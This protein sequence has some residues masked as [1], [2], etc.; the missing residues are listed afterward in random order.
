[1]PFD[2]AWQALD[3]PSLEH[4]IASA[5]PGGFKA[6][7]QL[8]LVSDRGPAR[9]SY[10]LECDARWR[11]RSLHVS[12]ATAG[13]T[14]TMTLEADGEGHWQRD[15]HPQPA[16]DG[17]IDVDINRT[18]LTNTLP[19]RRL[20]LS[21]GQARGLDV[22]YVTVPELE[23]RPVRQRYTRLDQPEPAYRYESGSFRADL[24]VDGDGF[25]MDYPRCWQRVGLGELAAR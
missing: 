25:V 1:M 4:V 7:G 9:A 20:K 18:P 24:P 5:D 15:G 19:I 13:E 3:E 14:R 11:V 6:D 17:C 12:V 8:V 10:Q 21:P 23:L 2:L 16:L 22:V